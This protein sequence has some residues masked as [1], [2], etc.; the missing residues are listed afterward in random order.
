[1]EKYATDHRSGNS[2]YSNRQVPPTPTRSYT[3][4]ILSVFFPGLG[5]IYLHKILKGF[6]IFVGFASAIGLFYLNSYPVR[7]W[8][9]LTR[10]QHLEYKRT[11]SNDTVNSDSDLDNSIQLWTLDNGK[12][13]MFRPSWIL[14]V[15]A[16]IQ[17]LFCWI[18]A[19]YDGW[20]GRPD[21]FIDTLEYD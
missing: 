5:Q 2:I 13:L 18:Y 20:R 16:S 11:S 8:E 4:M 1:M 9:D 15:T 7:G 19:V 3:A 12:T 17:A 14:K 21:T 6:F 10:F